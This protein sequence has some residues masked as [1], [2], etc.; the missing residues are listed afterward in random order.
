MGL[1]QLRAGDIVCFSNRRETLHREADIHVC[2]VVRSMYP[3][4][5][6]DLSA[7]GLRY[8]KT[9]TLPNRRAVT[10]FFLPSYDRHEDYFRSVALS[11]Y[12]DANC[13]A[14]PRANF[15]GAYVYR[16]FFRSSH[17]GDKARRYILYLVKDCRTHAP[18]ELL[19]SPVLCSYIP[20]ALYQA[21]YGFRCAEIMALDALNT[22]PHVLVNYLMHN[23]HWDYEQLSS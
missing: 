20:I 23:P 5:V 19:S 10:V 22:T 4:C 12:N 6:L 13:V 14:F 16:R 7:M 21:I 18:R 15:N 8:F 17:Y 2:V 1:Y 9:G 11:W 3:L